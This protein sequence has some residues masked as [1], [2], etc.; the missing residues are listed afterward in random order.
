MKKKPVR[1]AFCLL[2][3]VV[4]LWIILSIFLVFYGVSGYVFLTLNG[5]SMEPTLSDGS[6]VAFQQVEPSSI[7]VGEVI[8]F[9]I[10]EK[11]GSFN[12]LVA[13]RVM[14]INKKEGII[15]FKTKGDNND[16]EDPSLISEY[17]LVGR[18]VFHIP[19]GK[20]LFWPAM[21]IKYTD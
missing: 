8:T 10:L 17:L 6:L 4:I 16:I 5:H 20:Y 12:R 1:W 7:K 11:D 14:D 2:T 18:L 13:H 19:Q 15:Y 9:Y 3:A 21:L